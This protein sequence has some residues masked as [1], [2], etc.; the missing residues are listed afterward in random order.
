MGKLKTVLIVVAVMI[1]AAYATL[2][3]MGLTAL[4]RPKDLGIKYT[5]KDLE[6]LYAKI[7]QKLGD[8]PLSSQNGLVYTGTMNF[9]GRITQEE[10]TARLNSNTWKHNSIRDVQVRFNAD[11][12]TEMSGRLMK[13]NID[14][15]LKRFNVGG[16]DLAG[17]IDALP[18]DPV[19]YIKGK[20][21]I[22]DNQVNLDIE[23]AKV[24][25]FDVNAD[26]IKDRADDI[27]ET[28]M[29]QVNGLSVK[30]LTVS[31]SGLDFDGTLPGEIGT[32][33]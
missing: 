25:A 14:E 1:V 24:G 18:I 6:S 29:R 10:L 8:A 2:T 20:G 7:P 17:R 4:S 27:I 9:D 32:A 15:N 31:E 28:A 22:Y 23:E 13:S 5:E 12:S 3:L 21:S 19:F 26:A 33:K 16:F 11:G 30:S